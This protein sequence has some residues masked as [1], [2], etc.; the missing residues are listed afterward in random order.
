MCR[1]PG[2]II[3]AV[4]AGLILAGAARVPAADFQPY[5]GARVDEAATRQARQAAAASPLQPEGMLPTI[6]LTEA[7]FAQ[8]AAF[9]RGLG[10]TYKM[11]GA[12]GPRA[13][14]LP[15]GREIKDAYFIFDGAPDLRSSRHWAKVQRPFI[16]G[17]KMVGRTLR[18][19]DIREVTVIIEWTAR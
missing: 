8:V 19:E 17:A 18:F 13:P 2:K 11:P 16:G 1:R 3:L 12:Q 6:Y 15:G 4:V 5:P 10:R 7:P 14:K 9:Y